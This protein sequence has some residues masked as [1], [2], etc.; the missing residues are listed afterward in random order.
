MKPGVWL[1]PM[2]WHCCLDARGYP[3]RKNIAATYPDYVSSVAGGKR[4]WQVFPENGDGVVGGG[5]MCFCENSSTAEC[6]EMVSWVWC[7]IMD[8]RGRCVGARPDAGI[9]LELTRHDADL[10]AYSVNQTRLQRTL[11]GRFINCL[12][13]V[14]LCVCVCVCVLY[15][16]RAICR[17][18]S[19]V[20][21]ECT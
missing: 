17:P 16:S 13:V 10:T 21:H 6:C 14:C 5:V 11:L 12:L 9:D 8:R 7:Q 2:L 19:A 20:H 18:D 3:S 15:R 4:N 1:K